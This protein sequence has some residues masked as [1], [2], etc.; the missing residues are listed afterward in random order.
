MLDFSEFIAKNNFKE[1]AKAQQKTM[2]FIK[3]ELCVWREGVGFFF[4]F[5]FFFLIHGSTKAGD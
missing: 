1:P 2:N 3:K 4:F 5:S